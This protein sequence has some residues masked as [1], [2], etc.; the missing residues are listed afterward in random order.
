MGTM[1]RPRKNGGY[2]ECSS[3]DDLVGKGRC[4]HILGDSDKPAMQLERIQRGMYEVKIED[5]RPLTIKAQ[6]ESIVQFF[7]A[8]GH[9]DE[10]KC[11]DIIDFLNEED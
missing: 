3:P 6:R 7:E 1:M 10:T 2:S 5:N 4:C 8:M 11:R 9:L